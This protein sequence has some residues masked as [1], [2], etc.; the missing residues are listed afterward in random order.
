VPLW[1]RDEI[2]VLSFKEGTKERTMDNLR[3]RRCDGELT[4]DEKRGCWVCLNCYPPRS[5][6][7]SAPKKEAKY[8]D[9]KPTE[10]RVIELIKEQEDWI[11]DIVV[12]EIGNWHR[13]KTSPVKSDWRQQ[14]KD[15]GIPL[16]QRK[17]EDVIKDI[18]ELTGRQLGRQKEVSSKED[19][20]V[21]SQEQN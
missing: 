21:R 7:P 6:P 3:C 8:I 15:L 12:D 1:F 10:K 20:N 5:K 17:K 9:V 13:P 11:R 14:A 4:R 19:D 2:Q 16:F 18:E